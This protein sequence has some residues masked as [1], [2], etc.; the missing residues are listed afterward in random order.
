M[1]MMGRTEFGKKKYEAFSKYMTDCYRK[2]NSQHFS[3]S[4]GGKDD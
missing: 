3:V 1:S 4:V 2:E